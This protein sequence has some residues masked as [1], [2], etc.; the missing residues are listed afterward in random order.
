MIDCV[1]D[2][3]AQDKNQRRIVQREEKINIDA[4]VLQTIA[5]R[6]GGFIRDAESLLG[7]VVS[8]IGD[9]KKNITMT[10]TLAIL[11]RSDLH[12]I[13]SLANALINK[14][15]KKCLE[16]EFKKNNVIELRIGIEV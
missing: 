13:S 7:Q 10:D 1:A 2:L 16:F 12:S 6:S 15:T 11:P 3:G 4:E 5:L 8:L 14:D 9:D